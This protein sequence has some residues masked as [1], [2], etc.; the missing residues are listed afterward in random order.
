MSLYPEECLNAKDRKGVKKGRLPL[1]NAAE[2]GLSG[3]V[4]ALLEKGADPNARTVRLWTPIILASAI[5]QDETIDVL[6]KHGADIN[7]Q[8][9]NGVT[10]LHV[11]AELRSPDTLLKQGL[12][13]YIEWIGTH[14][15]LPNP[16]S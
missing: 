10:A 15:P 16:H 2:L 4:A 1:H 6:I 7:A 5:G 3:V 14:K 8:V 11:A 9:R 12:R 13:R